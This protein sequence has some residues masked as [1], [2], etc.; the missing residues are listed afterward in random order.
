[1]KITSTTVVLRIATCVLLLLTMA[2]SIKGQNFDADFTGKTLRL[3]FYHTGNSTEEIISLDR[4]R[5]EGPWPGSRTQLHD[6]TN[7]GKYHFEVID[8]STNRLLYSRGFSSI[9]GE[10]ESTGPAR[11]GIHRTL[12]EALLMP[13][14]RKTFQ[15][16]LR[17]R[18]ASLA[19][20]EIWSTTID[21]ESRFV[22]RSVVARHEVR[23]LQTNGPPASKVDL[24]FLGDGY[25]ENEKAKFHTDAERM[26][27][28][29]FSYE[30]FKS[31]RG[32][33][34]VR[35]IFV[36]SQE[37]GVSRPRAKIFRNSPLGTTYNAFDSERYILTF[38]DRK[39]RDA[40]ASTS[41]EFV[42]FLLNTNQ[43]GGGGIYNL[44]A[45][46]AM[47][48][49]YADY[50]VVH[51]FGHHFA[52]LGD[53]YYTSSVAYEDFTPPDT[54]PW[55]PNVTALLSKQLKWQDL[56]T[57]GIPLPTPWD[58][59]QYDADSIAFQ[60]ERQELRK[61]GAP[62]EEVEKL[63]D[64]E[65]KHFTSLLSGQL[66]AKKVGAFEGAGYESNGL[67]RPSADCIMFTRNDGGF[68]PVCRQAL[69][70]V[71]DLYSK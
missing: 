2:G 9:Y 13:E 16:R 26:T 42:I 37:S 21:P 43:Y 15:V 34:N 48:S 18:D 63:F 11:K 20:Q 40:A 24:L 8:L 41:Y 52:G 12:E 39:W 47:G 64:R 45:T 61:A 49:N 51:E 17:K 38:S 44:F 59:K 3:D 55:E 31:R 14:P 23:A 29:L 28:A 5:I 32:D 71:V 33:F 4:V 25:T 50:L 35:S 58:K 56:A 46:A 57:P 60:K 62:E 54:E 22:D 53:E 19:F 7:L 65:K 69:E 1:M 36:P 66:H 10:W 30:P 67:Y 6:L 68:C 27:E 70:R